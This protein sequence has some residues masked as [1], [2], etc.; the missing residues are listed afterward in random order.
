MCRP[1]HAEIQ[2][3]TPTARRKE[4]RVD[5]IRE[6]NMSETNK[7]LGIAA[8][9]LERMRTQRIPR[10]LELKA[11]VERGEKLEDRDLAFLH[12]VFAS[13]EQIMP[14]VDRHPEYQDLYA[15]ALDLYKSI[16]E[17]AL[18]NEKTG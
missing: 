12:E 13:A 15:Q 18:D 9:L 14:L 10:A 17:K 11:K 1:P 5:P 3:R 6:K 2:R 7:D 8:A 4:T 16:T